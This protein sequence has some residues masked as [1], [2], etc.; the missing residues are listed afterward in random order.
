MNAPVIKSTHRK[1]GKQITQEKYQKKIGKV[2][3]FQ[4]KFKYLQT[5]ISSQVKQNITKPF[6]SDRKFIILV[7]NY[8]ILT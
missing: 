3:S 4:H 8:P 2:F 7:G 5:F 1:S 6:Y